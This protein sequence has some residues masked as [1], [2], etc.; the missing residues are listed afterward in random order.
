MLDFDG[1]PERFNPLETYAA[2]QLDRWDAELAAMLA[3]QRAALFAA[4]RAGGG[5]PLADA[6][7][8]L[9]CTAAQCADVDA[10]RH[11]AASEQAQRA[12]LAPTPS[13]S[14]RARDTALAQ[15]LQLQDEFVAQLERVKV[16]MRN[17]F[18]NGFKNDERL[19]GWRAAL[20]H[21]ARQLATAQT[22]A[23][24]VSTAGCGEEDKEAVKAE[25][26]VVVEAIQARL[27]AVEVLQGMCAALTRGFEELRLDATPQQAQP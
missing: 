4:L 18:I 17:A 21:E 15:L 24:D 19:P 25:R 5:V 10:A 1:L 23:D 14:M 3:A 26:R 22:R 8:R 2:S 12:G 6:A 20:A 27:G 11:A 7:T 16:D 13:A 9:A